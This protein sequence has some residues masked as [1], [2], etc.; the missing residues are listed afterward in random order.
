MVHLRRV[1]VAFCASEVRRVRGIPLWY[2][3]KGGQRK[4]AVSRREGGRNEELIM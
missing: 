1:W 4:R 2:V 3:G